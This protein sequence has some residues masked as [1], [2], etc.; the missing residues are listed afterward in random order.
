MSERH[1]ISSSRT[2]ER[3]ARPLSA[4]NDPSHSPIWDSAYAL[5][6]P[7]RPVTKLPR[8]PRKPARSCLLLQCIHSPP[9]QMSLCVSCSGDAVTR[10]SLVFHSQTRIS[11]TTYAYCY[12]LM[13]SGYF[14]AVLVRWRWGCECSRIEKRGTRNLGSRS[15]GMSRRRVHL[16]KGSE[17]QIPDTWVLGNFWAS[18]PFPYHHVSNWTIGYGWSRVSNCIGS[19]I[20][21]YFTNH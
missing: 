11:L 12:A 1:P 5:T 18:W 20:V 16:P 8:V 4:G 15:F 19:E 21:P 13:L 3:P 7:S 6:S 2:I 10:L 17:Y 9:H 14:N